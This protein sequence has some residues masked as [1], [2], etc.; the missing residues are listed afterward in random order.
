MGDEPHKV[1]T[2]HLDVKAA[3]KLLAF[4]ANRTGETATIAPSVPG[5]GKG[6]VCFPVG[7]FGRPHQTLGVSKPDLSAP[8]VNIIAAFSPSG[9]TDEGV[10][11]QLFT[12][13][14]GTSMASPHVAG[15]AALL[16]DRHPDWTPGKIKSA[17]M[18]TTET[19][20][21]FAPDG[22]TP[23]DSFFTGSGRLDLRDAARPGVTF[24]VPPIDYVTHRD[25]LWNTNYPSLYV[26]SMPAT[27]TVQRTTHSEEPKTAPN[28]EIRKL[29]PGT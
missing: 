10:S 15:A 23:A 18:T 17:L 6:D 25:D 5:P 4:V 14:T 16:K 8:G 27:L 1:P 26:P 2:V 22:F 19:K 21:I 3:E 7:G 29:K 28:I 11:G 24:D 20:N 12:A 13:F 9:F